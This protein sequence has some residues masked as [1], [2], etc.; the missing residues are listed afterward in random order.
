MGS[1]YLAKS[2]AG[3]TLIE[4][5]VVIIVLITFIGTFLIMFDP[6]RQLNRAKDA[7]RQHDLAS[8]KTALDTYFNDKNCYPAALFNLVTTY[9]QKLPIDPI[10]KVSY[11]YENDDSACPQWVVLYAKLSLPSESACQLAATCR[12]RN[13]STNYACV[14][15][16][17]VNC[18][19]INVYTIP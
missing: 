19:T 9:I 3:L 17:S 6:A 11:P 12:P 4:L 5:L 13:F 14:P 7:Q 15:L 1:R 2:S 16:G 8:L 10:T 18:A